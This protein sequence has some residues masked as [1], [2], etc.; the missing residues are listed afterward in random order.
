MS[1]EFM[2]AH[3]PS[4]EVIKYMDDR[5]YNFLTTMQQTGE[6]DDTAV[7]LLADHGLHL[8]TLSN[9]DSVQNE[10]WNPMLFISMPTQ[11]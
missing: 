8:R 4:G 11:K 2:E 6:L 5:L 7:I 10:I 1:L 3:E 9:V